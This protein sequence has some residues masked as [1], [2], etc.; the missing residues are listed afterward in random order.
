MAEDPDSKVACE[1]ASKTGMIMVL[2]E[3]TTKAT[4]DYQRIIRGAIK[5]IG[6]NDSELGFDYKTCNVLI[7]I[8]QQSPDIAQVFTGTSLLSCSSFFF[9]VLVACRKC[10]IFFFQ[11]GS[12][13]FFNGLFCTPFV[14]GF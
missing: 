5:K 14:S 10:S 13:F 3:I 11:G 4:L 7:A 6:Y 8:E 9:F 1:S 2:G 12:L